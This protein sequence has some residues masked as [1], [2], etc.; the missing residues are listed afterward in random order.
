MWKRL[1][2]LA[3]VFGLAATAPPASAQTSCAPHELIK[4]RLVS[5]Y[6][7]SLIGRGLQSSMRLFEVWRSSEDGNW[8]ILMLKPDGV[9][10]IMATGFA[11]TDELPRRPFVDTAH[12]H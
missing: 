2:C 8:T 3:F 11:W 9:A 4:K 10:C 12:N 6:R 5:D 7:E 1:I